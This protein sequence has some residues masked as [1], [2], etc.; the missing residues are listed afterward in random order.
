MVY[1]KAWRIGGRRTVASGV[2]ADT[3]LMLRLLGLGVLS[4]QIG[5]QVWNMQGHVG[6]SHLHGCAPKDGVSVSRI[7]DFDIQCC[8]ET[9]LP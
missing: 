2:G 8:I 5:R 1:A 6:N 3:T 9:S 7:L 4:Q